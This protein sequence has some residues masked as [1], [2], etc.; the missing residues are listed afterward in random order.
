MGDNLHSHLPPSALVPVLPVPVPSSVIPSPSPSPGASTTTPAHKWRVTPAQ[1]ERL[2]CAF[3]E[4]PYPN[5]TQKG[6]LA[7]QL[8]VT[9]TQI[10]K[11]FQHRRE[12]LTRLG[13]FKAQYNRS[14]RTEHELRVLQ[15][16]FDENSYPT[17]DRL[18]EL[19]SQ[20][21]NVT[22]KQ[23]KLWFKHRRK[24]SRLRAA[25]AAAAASATNTNNVHTNTGGSTS[26]T[27]ESPP[28]MGGGAGSVTT[29]TGHGVDLSL[30]P[31]TPTS[32]MPVNPNA[33]AMNTMGGATATTMA[34]TIPIPAIYPPFSALELM[35]LRGAL[36]MSKQAPPLQALHSLACF[37]GRPIDHLRTFFEAELRAGYFWGYISAIE[38]QN[39]ANLQ[40]GGNAGMNNSATTTPSIPPQNLN[41]AMSMGA[42][43]PT[44]PQL[45]HHATAA[46]V[47]GSSV[48][49]PPSPFIVTPIPPTPQWSPSLALKGSGTGVNSGIDL[50]QASMLGTASPLS[51]AAFHQLGSPL[52]HKPPP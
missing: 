49:V 35:A 17:S 40:Q 50:R 9:A 11:W 10:S 20:L 14:R 46:L 48:P 38:A 8:G 42:V 19:E 51:A 13:L 39:T 16:A 27:G 3:S 5:P 30:S 2:L 37:L 15:M 18:A 47:S 12:S 31:P 41:I 7:S 28:L 24:Q 29:P 52:I 4:E 43:P 36:C 26:G 32:A 21:E 34:G 22:S 6:A 25:A 23:I 44:T 1:K 45:Q 33:V